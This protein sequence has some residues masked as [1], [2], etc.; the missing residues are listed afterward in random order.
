MRVLQ[1]RQRQMFLT[2]TRNVLQDNGPVG[3]RG[4]RG[5]EYAAMGAAPQLGQQLEIT[6]RFRQRGITQFCRG[7]SKK[8]WNWMS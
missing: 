8:S 1:A 2:G 5:Q 7:P 3:E 6:G 4:L